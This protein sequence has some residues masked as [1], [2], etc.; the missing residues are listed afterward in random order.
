D[1][2]VVAG[3]PDTPAGRALQHLGRLADQYPPAAAPATGPAGKRGFPVAELSAGSRCPD[4]AAP[5]LGDAGVDDQRAA[6]PGPGTLALGTRQPSGTRADP[7]AD[8]GHA[9][10]S[11]VFI[12][13]APELGAVCAPPVRSARDYLADSAAVTASGAGQ[14]TAGRLCHPA[15]LL[16]GGARCA[17]ASPAP[18][19]V[20]I[21]ARLAL[22]R[23]RPATGRGQLNRSIELQ[24]DTECYVP[25]T[26]STSSMSEASYNIALPSSPLDELVLVPP[27]GATRCFR[28]AR[29]TV[30][31]FS[32]PMKA[33]IH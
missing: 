32:T 30:T 14:P 11:P 17:A 13:A 6:V 21:A 29:A 1:R 28:P 27:R 20:E 19:L 10:Q 22:A 18:R 26:S 15:G 9:E 23:R 2:T 16:A 31:A 33:P 24:I 12:L 5:R 4:A 7:S 8:R 25:G 3:A